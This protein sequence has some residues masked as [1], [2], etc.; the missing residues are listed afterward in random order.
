MS[1][2]CQAHVEPPGHL[3]EA[4]TLAGGDV[5]AADLLAEDPVDAV[6]HGRDLERSGGHVSHS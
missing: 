4:Q 1:N 3:F 6:L 2:R 5:E